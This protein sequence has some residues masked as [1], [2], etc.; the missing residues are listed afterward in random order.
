MAAGADHVKRSVPARRTM[1]VGTVAAVVSLVVSV[2]APF[3]A[4]WLLCA[5]ALLCQV[6]AGYAVLRFRMYTAVAVRSCVI[7]CF[8]VLMFLPV[9]GLHG[10]FGRQHHT[11][12]LFDIA[13]VH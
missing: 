10:H 11:H 8:L 1:I 5:A 3:L 13:H 9:W 12:S 2:S 6:Y 7:M 4:T